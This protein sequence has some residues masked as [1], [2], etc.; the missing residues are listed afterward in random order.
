[1]VII[2]INKMIKNILLLFPGGKKGFTEVWSQILKYVLLLLALAFL[3]YLAGVK[4][5]G[6]VTWGLSEVWDKIFG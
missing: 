4:F 6:G 2:N 3:L 5:F 1:M